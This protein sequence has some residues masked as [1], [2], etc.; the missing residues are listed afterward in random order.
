MADIFSFVP[1]KL[2]WDFR[3]G[4]WIQVARSKGESR[5][6]VTE[7]FGTNKEKNK[8]YHPRNG[9]DLGGKLNAAGKEAEE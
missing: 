7:I 2:R 9:Q 1:K 6:N 3:D 8:K 5:N 4:C